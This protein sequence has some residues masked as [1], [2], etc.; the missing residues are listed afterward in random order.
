MTWRRHIGILPLAGGVALICSAMGILPARAQTV[1]SFSAVQC[2]WVGQKANQS[3]D[4]IVMP[5]IQRRDRGSNRND[6][7]LK[8]MAQ[9]LTQSKAL[10]LYLSCLSD[11]RLGS[12]R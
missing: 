4:R 6:E 8:A 9:E 12:E 3:L 1:D 2:R 7:T 10:Q 11:Q 5:L